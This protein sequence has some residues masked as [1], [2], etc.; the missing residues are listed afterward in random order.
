MTT[1]AERAERLNQLLVAACAIWTVV[2]VGAAAEAVNSGGADGR[3][4]RIVLGVIAIG[5]AAAGTWGTAKRQRWAPWTLLVSVLAPLMGLW[6]LIVI[7][8]VLAVTSALQ[9]DP[10]QR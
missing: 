1:T 3:W 9:R 7:P 4:W 6:L 2:C 8:A 10:T 5:G